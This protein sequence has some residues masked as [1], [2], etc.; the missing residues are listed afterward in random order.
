MCWGKFQSRWASSYM[1]C[2]EINHELYLLV[3]QMNKKKHYL[4]ARNASLLSNVLIS[5]SPR[6]MRSMQSIVVDPRMH[7]I[8]GRTRLER[9]AIL[10]S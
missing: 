6:L 5:A 4:P 9:A 1:I 8:S 7:D 3:N 2:L 10:R